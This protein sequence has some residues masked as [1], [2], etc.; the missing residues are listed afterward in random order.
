M[1]ITNLGHVDAPLRITSLGDDS[2][3]LAGLAVRSLP[4]ERFSSGH[5]NPDHP[6]EPHPSPPVI[7]SGSEESRFAKTM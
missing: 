3:A 5:T 2:K 7:L 6:K 4:F 1:V